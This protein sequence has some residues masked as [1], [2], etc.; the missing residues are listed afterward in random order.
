MEQDAGVV[1]CNAVVWGGNPI[2]KIRG[3]MHIG[4]GKIIGVF[5]EGHDLARSPEAIDLKGM[6][7]IPG[8]IDAH[9]HFSPTAF[10]SRH[11]DA[12][13]WKGKTDA[14][15]AIHE[16]CRV[17]K[18]PDEWVVFSRMDYSK[19]K[20]PSPP[21]LKEIDGASMGH[22]V[23]VA[24]ITLHRGL[25]STEAVKRGGL[26]RQ[27]LRIPGD[28]ATGLGGAMK[29]V[30]WE[31]AL[32][33]VLY[34]MFRDVIERYAE[35]EKREMILDEAKRCL[36]LG[37]THVHDPGVPGDVQALL[38]DVLK[39]TPLKISWSV[40][41]H[42]SLYTPPENKD[43]ELAV[44]SP[45]APRSAKF[46]LDGA[47]RTAASMPLIAGFK[48]MVRAGS[49]S[50]AEGSLRPL[51]LIFEQK[52]TMKGG[53]LVMPYK[54]FAHTGE[55]IRAAAPFAEK[56]YRLVIHAL[57]NDAAL[58]AA[59]AISSLRPAGGASVEHMLVMEE[60]DLD[61]FAGCGAAAS[62]QPGFIPIYAETLERQGAIPYLKTFALGSMK[63]RGIPI[64][65][66][67]DGPCG[68]DDPL[69]N[70]RRAVDRMKMDG[71]MLD[72]GEAI[73]QEEALAAVSMGGSISMGNGNAGL[74]AGSSATFCIVSGD[75]FLDSSGVT[76]T[77]IDGIRAY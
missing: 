18:R 31:E 46:F 64:C 12:G 3:G 35:D 45:H 23:V 72:P 44:H 47:H 8:L 41:A 21:S 63:K 15:E 4:E 74:S 59:E 65:I 57:G 10:F 28:I 29:G 70:A 14:L 2:R 42:E 66:S 71:S 38:Q 52:I 77:W 33:R 11:G 53:R 37:L 55:F 9:R 61:L 1:F 26:K 30:V 58:Q 62:I 68:P 49:D 36:Q 24:D 6:H 69:F 75:P 7:I 76:Q 34:A 56:G 60:R 25:V 39:S 16:A 20:N 48:S 32:G 40:T 22:P 27:G 17:A 54:R 50:F 51:K 73:S 67:S 43:E 5:D 13:I 19:W